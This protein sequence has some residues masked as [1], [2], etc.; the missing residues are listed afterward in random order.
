MKTI[1]FLD[2]A[3]EKLGLRT[4]S[5]LS[6]A[7]G[8]SRARIGHY[9]TGI[10]KPDEYI[11]FQIAEILNVEPQAVISAVRAEGEQDPD[12]RRFWE[13]YARRYGVALTVPFLLAGTISLTALATLPAPAAANPIGISMYYA[14]LQLLTI[15]LFWLFTSVKRGI[16]PIDKHGIRTIPSLLNRGFHYGYT[17]ACY[18]L[19]WLGLVR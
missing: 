18:A 14:K 16:F 19:G 13:Q 10:R 12:K 4:D 17:Q 7:L 5:E 15:T 2:A 3:K 1:E 11:C 9:R 8:T 6:E